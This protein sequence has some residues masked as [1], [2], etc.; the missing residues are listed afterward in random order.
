MRD[1]IR[2]YK[3]IATHIFEIFHEKT[4]IQLN[5]AHPAIGIVE[6]IRILVD[7]EGLTLHQAWLIT[8]KTFSYTSHSTGNEFSEK[9]SVELVAKIL[10]RH[11]EIINVLNYFFIDKVK[12]QYPGDY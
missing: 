5:D 3:K 12:K 7:E 6:L 2:R 10:P 4:A 1:I 11:L 8:C 9:W